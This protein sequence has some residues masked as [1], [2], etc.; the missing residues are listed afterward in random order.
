MILDFAWSNDIRDRQE[1]LDDFIRKKDS[2]RHA[3]Y[4]KKNKKQIDKKQKKAD[5]KRDRKTYSHK[6]YL[7]HKQEI[8]K[9]CHD[10]YEADK[11][12]RRA[13]AK[14]YYHEHKEEISKRRKELRNAKKDDSYTVL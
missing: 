6:Y 14:A 1:E 5:K 8:N 4:Y 12:K 2:I 9:A 13:K 3:R 11:E 7:E 10:R